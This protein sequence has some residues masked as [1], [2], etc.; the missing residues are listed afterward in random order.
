MK[1][2]KFNTQVGLK[3]FL[4]FTL[5][6]NSGLISKMFYQLK[7]TPPI[8]SED[9]ATITDDSQELA[10]G[11]TRQVVARGSSPSRGTVDLSAHPLLQ[12]EFSNLDSIVNMA[13]NSADQAG[14]LSYQTK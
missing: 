8:V 14:W 5:F 3:L 9:L 1:K 6:A 13:K 2:N 10:G 12:P 7:S 4:L 11:G